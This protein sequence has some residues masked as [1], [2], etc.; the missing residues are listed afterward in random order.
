LSNAGSALATKFAFASYADAGYQQ[1]TRYEP[2]LLI[3]AGTEG[4]NMNDIFDWAYATAQRAAGAQLWERLSD[5]ERMQ[6][7]ARQIDRM[8]MEQIEHSVPTPTKQLPD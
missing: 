8:G 3:Q 5:T 7:I 4:I 1:L 6:A 2:N